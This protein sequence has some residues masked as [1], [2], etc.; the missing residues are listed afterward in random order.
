MS[1]APA[2]KNGPIPTMAMISSIPFST[3]AATT[4]RTSTSTQVRNL[5]RQELTAF[6]GAGAG[7]Y[8]A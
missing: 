5:R 2:T 4:R 8:G 3:I 6:V 7:Y 1:S